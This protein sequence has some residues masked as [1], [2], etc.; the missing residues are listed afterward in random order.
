[1]DGDNKAVRLTHSSSDE[2]RFRPPKM[3]TY[4]RNMGTPAVN[5]IIPTGLP[6]FNDAK[7]YTYDSEKAKDLVNE[8][9]KATGDKTP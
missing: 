6:S 2:L 9:K 1:M 3:I 5:G 8:Y 7:G 4:L